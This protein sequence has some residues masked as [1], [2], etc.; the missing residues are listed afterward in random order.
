MHPVSCALA[1]NR[2]LRLETCDE[3]DLARAIVVDEIVVV[4]DQR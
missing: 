2:V 4:V 3:F 1:W